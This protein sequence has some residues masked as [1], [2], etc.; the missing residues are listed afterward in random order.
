MHLYQGTL[1]NKH[2]CWQIKPQCLSVLFTKTVLVAQKS[3]LIPTFSTEDPML[4]P[5]L[6]AR[7]AQLR[8]ESGPT[9]I[10]TM[11]HP[12]PTQLLVTNISRDLN[13]CSNV[14]EIKIQSFL[15]TCNLSTA[16]MKQARPLSLISFYN[17]SNEC[18]QAL[19]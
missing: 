2:H 3:G 11:V 14:T 1:G 7:P 8:A 18:V 10:L 6:G 16:Q 5:Q 15:Q 17:L 4:K 19:L 9:R 13:Q 12:L